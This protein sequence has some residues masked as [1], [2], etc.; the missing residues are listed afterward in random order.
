MPPSRPSGGGDDDD[1]VSVE[2]FDA[3]VP[4]F[5]EVARLEE[6]HFA[7]Q[8][9]RQRM[10]NAEFFKTREHARQRAET[11]NR[12]NK[13]AIARRAAKTAAWTR[14][15][16]TGYRTTKGCVGHVTPHSL[17]LSVFCGVCGEG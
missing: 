5:A 8:D 13:E 3:N 2:L 10:T 6:E 11:A 15:S 16:S 17:S 14:L 12:N 4:S 7:A 1:T 9:G